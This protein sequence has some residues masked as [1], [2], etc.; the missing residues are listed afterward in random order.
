MGRDEEGWRGLEERPGEGWGGMRR[1]GEG[2]GGM[3][4]V[5]EG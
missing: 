4:K 2:Q 3:G 5:G 1:Y